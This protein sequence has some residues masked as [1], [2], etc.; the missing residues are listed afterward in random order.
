MSKRFFGPYCWRMP[1]CSLRSR[2]LRAAFGGGL[3][4]SLTS[5]APAGLLDGRSGRR[6]GRFDRT[7]GWLFGSASG[8]ADCERLAVLG[9]AVDGVQQLSQG[10][11]E[12]EL[13]RFPGGTEALIEGTQP[14]VSSNGSQ[15]RHPQ[16]AAQPGIA[17]WR[18]GGADELRL[19]DCLRPGTTPT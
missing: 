5:A 10:G 12:R 17:H 15:H 16:R 8:E 9:D 19:P 1:S 6:D 13:G 18:D 7:T 3:R 2:T 4:P 14:S 11:D